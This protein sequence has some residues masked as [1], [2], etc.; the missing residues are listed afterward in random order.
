M[1]FITTKEKENLNCELLLLFYM[2]LNLFA[3]LIQSQT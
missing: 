1:Y 2:T 3:F